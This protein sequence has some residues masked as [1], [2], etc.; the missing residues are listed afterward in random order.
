M[1]VSLL[2]WSLLS[3]FSIPA[4]A[5]PSDNVSPSHHLVKRGDSDVKS[6]GQS[7]TFNGIEVPPMKALTPD[8]FDDTIKDGYWFVKQYSPSC[9]HCQKIAP[10][11]QTLYEFYYTSDPLSSSSS[12]SSNT[13]S[14]N[15]FHG[16][17]N[18]HFAE[19]NCLAH[20]DLCRKLDVKYF[21]TFALYHNGE[22]VEQYTGKKSMEGISEFVE[23]KL[24]QIK[25]GSRPA[26]GLHLPKPGD[27]GVDTQA[28]PE[29]PVAKDKDR[30]AGTKA[31]EKHNEQAAQ[32]AE[33]ETPADKTSSKS[34]PKPKPAPANP[35]GISVPLT[36]ESFQKLVTTTQDPWFIKFYAPWC[37]HCQAL[38]PNWREMAK[39]M[40]GVLNVGEVNCDAESRLC[41][42]ARV[43]AFPTM[44]F[45]RGGE[46]VEYTGLRGLGDLVSYAK[47]AVDVGSGVQDVDATTFKELEE[48]EDVIFLYFYDH[49][50]TSEDFEALERLTLSLVGHA[51]LVKTNSATLA[52][53]FKIST[54][55]RLLVSRD[56]RPS[57]YNALAPK[58]MR[59]FRQILNWMRTV[60]L[61]IVPELTA[62]NAREIMDG[63]YVVLGILS[64]KHSDEFLQ[65][66]RELKNAA[67]EWMDKQTQLF[68]LE[69][70]ELR[71]AKQLRIEE[72]E[73]RNDQRALRAAKN[74]RITIRED[75][76]KQVGFAWIDG[77]FWERWLRTTYGIDVE[78][79]ERVVI[80]D[81]D[82]RRYWD[83]SSSGA[84]IMA[85]R[86]S[87]LE[88]IPLVIANPPKLTPKSTVGTFESVFF[89]T[90]TFISGHPIL[91]FIILTLSVAG[92]T[93]V[94]RGRSLRRGARGGILGV[95]GNT[96]GG[97]FNLD[98]KEGL[99]NGGSTGKVD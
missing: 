74:M 33:D 19:M 99:L 97:F 41:K 77:D 48:K 34:K 47:K 53:R 3:L 94:A 18:F 61:P 15:S 70:A 28:Q 67:L 84:S 86:T 17:Y 49:A 37:H 56:G 91:F 44:Y 78:N 76:K 8:N 39:E 14:L 98:G 27:K 25:P 42:D 21:P 89:F 68:Q 62:S 80:N 75:D 63:K 1:R 20:G 52:E 57:Y 2:A 35:Q 69:R 16:F 58:D 9:P 29:A 7:T 83:T 59:D 40:Q 82:N 10:A 50:T 90:R 31:G 43:S 26:Q 32:L 87:I 85:S 23:E 24:E 92:A 11:W 81:Q 51:R 66:K 22:L 36:A 12:K 95:T 6:E 46:R 55:P 72:A 65:S 4:L 88:T 79:G 38:A 54:W 45:F 64:R 73:D 93:I 5:A 60:W 30:E 13:D 96:G 71:D